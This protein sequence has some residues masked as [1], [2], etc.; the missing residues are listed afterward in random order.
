MAACTCTYEI[1]F[2]TR[3]GISERRGQKQECSQA[4]ADWLI[5]GTALPQIHRHTHG[6]I[7]GNLTAGV[8]A[9]KARLLLYQAAFANWTH[10]VL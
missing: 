10:N 5:K 8:S 4:T 9:T 7:V 6:R 2:A 1:K 3:I